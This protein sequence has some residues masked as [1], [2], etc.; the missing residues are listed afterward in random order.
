MT[1]TLNWVDYIILIIFFFSM[2]AGFGRGLVR[3]IISL[4]TIVAAFIVAS[5][6]ASSL[7]DFFTSSAS[8][9]NVVSQASSSTGVN[10][11]QSANYVALGLS[12]TLIFVATILGGSLIGYFINMAFQAGVLGFGN[13]VLGGVFGLVRGFIINLVII[14]VVQLTPFSSQAA[15][16]QSQMVASFQPAVA[17]LGG[18][19]SPALADIKQKIGGSLQDVNQSVQSI[20]NSYTGFSQ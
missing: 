3:E 16:Q 17:W 2:L 20:T 10:A 1:M 18:I 12:F 6:F 4:A 13:R 19:V 14:F 15:W 11:A 8:V 7:A 9:Q 5:M